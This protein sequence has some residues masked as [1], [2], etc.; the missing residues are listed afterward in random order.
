MKIL[1]EIPKNWSVVHLVALEGW[2]MESISYADELMQTGS[3]CDF[4]GCKDMWRRESA[5]YVVLSS[6]PSASQHSN[7][8]D[9]A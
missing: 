8:L 7:S 3:M 2:Y 4:G 9:T 5:E 1:D 6:K